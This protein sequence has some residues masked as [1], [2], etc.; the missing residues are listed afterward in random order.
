MGQ[1]KSASKFEARNPKQAMNL[2][3]F[4]VSTNVQ[5][6]NDL[7]RNTLKFE[8]WILILFRNS[9]L[10]FRIFINLP[11]HHGGQE[12]TNLWE[13]CDDDDDCYHGYK[14]RHSTAENR[15]HGNIFHY[16]G[17]GIDV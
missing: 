3:W 11:P 8:I 2:I 5:N 7:N 10:G 16:S 4:M 13:K 17:K 14:K 12:E 6:I 1:G 9:K 15:L